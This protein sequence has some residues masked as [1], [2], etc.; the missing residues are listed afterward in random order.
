M[1]STMN[2]IMHKITMQQ[3]TN[4]AIRVAVARVGFIVAYPAVELLISLL[5][6]S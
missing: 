1:V 5:C 3:A 6:C 2:T 4:A